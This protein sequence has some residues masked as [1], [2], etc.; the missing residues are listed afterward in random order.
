MIK[1][2]HNEKIILEVRRHWFMLVAQWLP[3]IVVVFAPLFI[4]WG[5]GALGFSSFITL[6]KHPKEILTLLSATWVLFIWIALFL[7]WTDY[8][9]DILIVTDQRI[10]DIEQRGLFSREISTFRLDRIQDITASIDGVIPTFLDFGDLHIQTAGEI[11]DI[12]IRG[13]PDPHRIRDIVSRAQ[14]TAIEKGRMVR[15]DGV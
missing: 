3:L 10:F 13:V 15:I 9:L 12:I 1:L 14:N 2:E 4:K 5:F 7:I 8:Y 6:A 11:P